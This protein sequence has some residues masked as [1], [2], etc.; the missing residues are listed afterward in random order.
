[1]LTLPCT[2][3]K[4]PVRVV[5]WCLDR[6]TQPDLALPIQAQVRKRLRRVLE[7]GLADLLRCI[8]ALASIMP[9]RAQQGCQYPENKLLNSSQTMHIIRD[10]ER[11]F[12]RNSGF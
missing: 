1:M 6:S 2:A 8:L 5:M 10:P 7:R 12:D 9:V 11:Y 3:P 4:L